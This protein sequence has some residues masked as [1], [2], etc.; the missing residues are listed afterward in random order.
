MYKGGKIVA[1]ILTH[2]LKKKKKI[3]F[4]LPLCNAVFILLPTI[5]LN[6]SITS[7][8]FYFI[9]KLSFIVTKWYALILFPE[10]FYSYF[11]F[12]LCGLKNHLV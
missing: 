2:L 7:T 9:I 4:S 12:T 3:I 5:A 10:Y 11:I 1:I 6:L 8:Y